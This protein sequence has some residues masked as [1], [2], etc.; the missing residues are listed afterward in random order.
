MKLVVSR[1]EPA[2]HEAVDGLAQP[3]DG[4]GAIGARHHQLCDHRVVEHRD[5]RALVDAGV[6][7]YA[8]P[9]WRPVAGQAAD[10]GQ[11]VAVGILGVDACL[12]G[13]AGELH[14]VLGEGQ[15]LAGGDADHLL[16]QVQPRHHLGDRVLHLQAGVHLEEVEVEV[17]V[18]DELDRAG[19]AV[20]HGARQRAGLLA[21]GATRGLVQ[22]HRRRLLD[23]L[24]VTALDRALA[25]AEVDHVAVRVGE[26]L[27]LDVARLLDVLLAED[28]VV[29]EAGAC[30]VGGA[31][32]GALHLGLG[33]GDAHAL[34]TAAGR[35]L[36][37]DREADLLGDALGLGAVRQRLEVTRHRADPRLLRQP[38]GL[39]LVAH[40]GDRVRA[41][42]DED[43]ALVLQPLREGGVLGEEAEAGVHG[44][45]ASRLH[46]LD[47]AVDDQV[48][49]RR[50]RRADGHGL[51]GLAHVQGV[52]V[53]LG[54]DGDGGDAET[55][56]GAD[57]AAGD[58]AA[59]GDQD[60]VEHRCV[61]S[62]RFPVAGLKAACCCA[63]SAGWRAAC[64]AA[65][66]ASGRCVAAWCA[67]G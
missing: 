27:H 18:D 38:L 49:L 65:C 22:A 40:G 51:V 30:L 57:D 62:F 63:S 58:L 12:D 24:L 39:D 67:A 37:H 26:H 15:L 33:V 10:G 17:L 47:D 48:A 5:L 14:L 21:H 34:A 16:D 44:L 25:L 2:D 29:A 32:E 6:D 28:A 46:G 59:V 8:R 23:H 61:P 55:P 31:L 41:R 50:G 19:G 54:V 45:R 4:L 53:G 3:R 36:E 20:V 42:A 43:D 7:A 11:E 60:L 1:P 64:C 52:G 9:R 13:P 56:A 35:G 66:E